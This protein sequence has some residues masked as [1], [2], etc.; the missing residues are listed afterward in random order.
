MNYRLLAKKL[1]PIIA[2]GSIAE[3]SWAH[4]GWAGNE[5]EQFELTGTVVKVVSL[6]GPHA[7][8]QIDVDGQVWEIT[9][10]PPART[11]RAGLNENT[12]PLGAEITVSGHRSGDAKKFEIKTERVTHQGKVYNVYPDRE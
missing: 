5:D 4:H 11:E 3:L 12:L 7:N 8:L 10:A 9:L 2:L 6:A 1:L